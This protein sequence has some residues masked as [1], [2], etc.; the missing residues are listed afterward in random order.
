M[1]LY[2]SLSNIKVM[3]GD[4]AILRSIVTLILFLL[5]R[6]AFSQADQ[7]QFNQ[8]IGGIISEAANIQHECTVGQSA[9]TGIFMVGDNIS[10]NV[11]FFCAE[12][13]VVNTAPFSDAGEDQFYIETEQ[14][15]LDGNASFDPQGDEL[16]YIWE[17]LDGIVLDNS[18]GPQPSFT[19][20][21]VVARRKYRFTLT[22]DDGE[23]SSGTDT[24][25]IEVSDPDWVPEVYTNSMTTYAVVTIDDVIAEECDYVG[26]YVNDECRAASEVILFEGQA[27]A[28]FNVQ[29]EFPEEVEFRVYDY[30]EDRVCQAPE[31]QTTAPGGELGSFTDPIVIA[32]VCGNVL[33]A[34][35]QVSNQNVC[36]GESVFIDFT[37]FAGSMA[38]F[39]WFFDGAQ[40]LSGEGAGPYEL[41]WSESGFKNITLDISENGENSNQA[42]ATITVNP[43][44]EEITTEFVCSP[45]DTMTEILQL[46]TTLGCDSTIILERLYLPTEFTLTGADNYCGESFAA[47][48][49]ES[50]AGGYS[51][52]WNTGESSSEIN[53]IANGTYTVTITDVNGCTFSESIEIEDT[54]PLA[55]EVE[56]ISNPDCGT[57][58]GV[59]TLTVN[60]GFPPYTFQ[61]D[62]GETTSTADS[63]IA[64][65]HLV[66]IEDALGCST[67]QDV[68]ILPASNLPFIADVDIQNFSCSASGEI[69]ITLS[70]GTPPFSFS[71]SSGQETEDIEDL[72]PGSYSLTVTDALGCTTSIND[73]VVENEGDEV[74][75]VIS[76]ENCVLTAVPTSG[77]APYTFSWSNGTLIESISPV[78][79]DEFY[80]VSITDANGC[81]GTDSITAE[82]GIVDA[83]F[84]LIQ[85]GFE[86]SLS[87]TITSTT[88]L[89][90]FG[91]GS[92][93]TDTFPTYN[94]QENGTYE[95]QHITFSPCGSDTV[96]QVVM[97]DVVGLNEVKQSDNHYLLYP[98]PT[99]GLLQI[100]AKSGQ[101]PEEGKLEILVL[102]VLGQ[103]VLRV[104]SVQVS[105]RHSIDMHYLPDGVYQ[106]MIRSVEKTYVS[107]IV[108]NS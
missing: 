92:V 107:R 1:L 8:S 55:S 4:K 105:G 90:D 11:G 18:S 84:E 44:Y 101:I 77:E 96:T 71:W 51:Y 78:F 48:N 53:N 76:Q 32:A 39:S 73:L 69:D 98:N 66:V 10:G 108:K 22:V 40:V 94:Y 24:V 52:A 75:L 35:F 91:D 45:L 26:A 21:D 50:G 46:T 60:G 25:V 47:V 63:L 13:T 9:G 85:D 89:W 41:S 100:E 20:P 68:F 14:V 80:S 16:I 99:T 67:E 74:S 30:S 5:V 36:E 12:N 38:E 61:W 70:Q 87:P 42:A 54:P 15:V 97:V 104:E 64:G 81:F 83:G 59:A 34:S 3:K 88:H 29:T 7:V 79:V 23:L 93:S 28:V 86:I 6:Y 102:D 33:S 56:V 95:V 27:Y 57:N 58:F 82:V 65:P 17:S 103:L 43:S 62:N 37:G 2:S 49:I 106:I 31:T 19:A 72:T